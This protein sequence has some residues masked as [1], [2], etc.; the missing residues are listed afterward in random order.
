MM[1]IEIDGKPFWI[2]GIKGTVRGLQKWN[3]TIV[4]KTGNASAH[5][6]GAGN[7]VVRE[8][9]IS[10]QNIQKQEFW[11]V[12][13][14]GREMKVTGNYEFR[15][16]QQALLIWGNVKPAQTGKYLIIQNLTT[17]AKNRWNIGDGMPKSIA[18]KGILKVNITYWGAVILICG[19]G[20][21]ING[22]SYKVCRAGLSDPHDWS[23]SCNQ[24][25]GIWIFV[26]LAIIPLFYGFY[27]LAKTISDN[28]NN[29]FFS[30]NKN[31]DINLNK[32]PE[33]INALES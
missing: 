31:L 22:I 17:G 16:G 14:G 15:E 9:T 19:L 28:E 11:I 21:A 27:K 6:D 12:S 8:S 33:F 3:E 25:S 13:P 23:N 32:N 2:N 18:R 4:Q 10:T 20:A 30:V 29:F 24:L 1:D 5:H 26:L 7:I